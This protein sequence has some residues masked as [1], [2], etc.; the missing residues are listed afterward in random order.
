VKQN[1]LG[2]MATKTASSQHQFSDDQLAEVMKKAN[3]QDVSLEDGASTLSGGQVQLLSIAQALLY[4][5]SKSLLLLDEPT[6][7][8]DPESQDKVLNNLFEAAKM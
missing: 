2:L 7:H 5:D 3:L 1:L 8:L 6:S 4:S